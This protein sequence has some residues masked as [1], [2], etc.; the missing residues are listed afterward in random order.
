MD[1]E[2]LNKEQMEDLRDKCRKI[3]STMLSE[4]FE[5]VDV[6]VTKKTDEDSN[7]E[8]FIINPS[9]RTLSACDAGELPQKVLKALLSDEDISKLLPTRT[10]NNL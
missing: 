8:F 4:P 2:G 3:V 7:L 6:N 5:R 9:E 10:R 1:V